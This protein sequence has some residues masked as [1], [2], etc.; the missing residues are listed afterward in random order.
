M[1]E[2]HAAK[3]R[4]RMLSSARLQKRRKFRI[5]DFFPSKDP[6]IMRSKGS[7]VQSSNAA[8]YS[9]SRKLLWSERG[10][11]TFWLLILVGACV[12]VIVRSLEMRS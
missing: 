8:S 3:V 5:L 1:F 7:E 2:A 11:P 10:R 4:G 9:V 12:L 6:T